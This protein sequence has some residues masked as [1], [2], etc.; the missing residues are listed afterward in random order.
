MPDEQFKFDDDSGNREG[1]SSAWGDSDAAEAILCVRPVDG[2]VGRYGHT[3]ACKTPPG[4]GGMFHG[5]PARLQISDTF[6]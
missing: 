2:E 5:A 1:I 6:D 3:A 4:E